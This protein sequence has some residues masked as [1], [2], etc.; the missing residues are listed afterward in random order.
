MYKVNVYVI[1]YS[2]LNTRKKII[3]NLE[4]KLRSISTE[5]IDI[6]ITNKVISNFDPEKIQNDFVAKIFEN[7][8]LPNT[9]N[10]FFNQFKMNVPQ[11][12]VIS[13]ALKHFEVYNIVKQQD[14][15][16]INI[17]V[18]DDVF[19]NEHFEKNFATFIK[20]TTKD[21]FDMVFFGL[22]GNKPHEETNDMCILDLDENI[23]LIP[24]CD[25][26]F[27]NTRCAKKL[28]ECFVPIRYPTN[29]QLTYLIDKMKFKVGRTYPNL[30][31][32]GSKLGFYP[33]TISSNNILLFN[34]TYKLIY[35]LLEKSELN[36]DE[37][38]MVKTAFSNNNIENNPD[39]MFL[40][41]L[42]N[43]KTKHFEECKMF[44]DKA[45]LE[46]EKH[47]SCINNQS[48]ILQNYIELCK[49]IQ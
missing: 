18:E 4:T 44:F 8:D 22:P 46:Y 20:D 39:F 14:D 49:H 3:T 29:I 15:N 37:I 42:F 33:S 17:I 35:K 48:A 45:I 19:Y 5:N 30:M 12:R 1:H 40:E 43:L 28:V 36:Q 24:C 41:G 47:N 16:S 31:V 13:N 9:E 10:Q 2:N 38:Q 7:K 23:K 26:Y 6:N 21:N 11:S 34:N 27:I 32:D 25:S